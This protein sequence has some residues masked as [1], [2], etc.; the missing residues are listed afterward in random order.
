MIGDVI[1]ILIGVG[2]IALGIKGF[3]ATGLPFTQTKRITGA[4][5]I[6]IGILCILFGIAAIA[7]SLWSL[8]HSVG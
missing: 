6:V 3:T 4:P 7:G 5:A 8:V 2:A 1:G